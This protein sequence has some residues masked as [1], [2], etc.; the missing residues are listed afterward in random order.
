MEKKMLFV[1]DRN[2]L[3]TSGEL[4]LIKNRAEALFVEAGIITDFIV[5]AKMTRITNRNETINAGGTTII[6][7]VALSNPFSSIGTYMAIRKEIENRLKTN[8]YRTVVLSGPVMISYARKIHEN[9]HI[10]VIADIHGSFEDMVVFSKGGPFLKKAALNMAYN[11]EKLLLKRNAKNT[12]GFFVVT[13]ALEEYIKMNYH[14][15][16][17]A[18]FFIIPCATDT[19][20]FIVKEHLED[21][22]RYRDKY[23]IEDNEIVF[24]YSGGVSPWQ[25]VDKTIELYK[26]TADNMDI[27]TR[28]LVFSH[29]REEIK[30]LAGDDRRIQVDSYPP[31]ELI[32]V[33]HAGDFAFLLRENSITNNVAFPNKYLEYVQSGMKIITTPY[34][35]EIARQIAQYDLGYL[36]DFNSDIQELVDYIH[37]AKDNLN[38]EEVINTVLVENSFSN[39]TQEFCKWYYAEN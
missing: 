28:M 22:K 38:G 18:K 34:V 17:K 8:Q 7:K 30:Q 32:H 20:Q 23:G 2:V 25:C 3:T 5:L 39:T 21:R 27:K 16:D 24:I 4:R 12:D 11:L 31:D 9:L 26:K 15:S 37:K 35:K 1:T 19:Q 13:D 14:I 10:P 29:R 6:K 33:L 36:Y